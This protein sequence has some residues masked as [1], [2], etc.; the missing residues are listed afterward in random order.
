VESGCLHRVS[1]LQPLGEQQGGLIDELLDHVH[2]LRGSPH[3][4]DDFSVIEALGSIE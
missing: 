3:L 1:I 4:E 2:R